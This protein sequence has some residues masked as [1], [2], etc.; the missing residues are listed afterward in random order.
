MREK[1][2][3]AMEMLKL[4]DCEECHWN[5][6]PSQCGIKSSAIETS[7]MDDVIRELTEIKAL[8]KILLQGE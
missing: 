8:L 7:R 2:C 6:G 5:F 4:E 1:K 3:L